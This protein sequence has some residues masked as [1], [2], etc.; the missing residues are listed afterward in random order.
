MTQIRTTVSDPQLA[1]KFLSRIEQAVR[2][3]QEI[4]TIVTRWWA[5]Y[6]IEHLNLEM[7]IKKRIKNFQPNPNL[8]RRSAV[9]ETGN[10]L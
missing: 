5:V 3:N 9:N 4:C 1:F 2:I 8:A 7:V 10:R 6:A